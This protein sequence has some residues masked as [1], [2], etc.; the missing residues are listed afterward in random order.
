MKKIIALSI[1]VLF[2]FC[3]CSDKPETPKL[4]TADML[5]ITNTDLDFQGCRSRFEAVISA[6]KSKVT[7][8]EDAHNAT[9][10]TN[11]ENEYFLEK[12][13]VL[14]AFEPFMLSDFAVTREFNSQ[15]TA[16]SAK[17]VFAQQANG[18]DIIYES[19]G[20]TG[21]V[22]QMVSENVVKKYSV[23]YNEKSDGFRYVYSV[24]DSGGETVNEFLEF[25]KDEN[26]AYLIQSNTSRCRIEFDGEDKIVYFCCGELNGG[27][28]TLEESLFEEGKPSVSDNWVLARGKSSYTNIHTYDGRVLTHEDC[29]SGPWKS[30]KINEND[31]ASAFYAR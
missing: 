4:K 14:T 29:S 7:V 20:G 10:K 26:G 23:E 8:L 18:M 21:F 6:M 19:D 1:A 30:I 16:E 28:F 11:A 5:D 25:M 2:L 3:S 17:S 27:E 31:F 22:L 9:V 24:E 13:F 12:D 15:L